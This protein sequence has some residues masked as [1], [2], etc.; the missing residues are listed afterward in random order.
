MISFFRCCRHW[1]DYIDARSGAY[2]MVYSINT[3]FFVCVLCTRRALYSLEKICCCFCVCMYG[4]CSPIK[5]RQQ[6]IGELRIV[7]LLLPYTERRTWHK[8]RQRRAGMMFNQLLGVS[9]M[10]V[11]KHTHCIYTYKYIQHTHREQTHTHTHFGGVAFRTTRH[12]R[13]ACHWGG[14]HIVQYAL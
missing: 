8:Q 3:R 12:A 14:C 9:F 13:P 7:C 1:P 10:R 4:M 11:D 6:R 5:G 2:C